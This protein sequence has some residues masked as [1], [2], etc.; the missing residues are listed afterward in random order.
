MICPACG[1]KNIP[2]DDECESCRADLSSL[3]GVIPKSKI[4]KV[5]IEDSI[6]QLQ[7]REPVVVRPEATVFEAVRMMNQGKFGCVLVARNGELEG[8]LTER[9]ILFKLLSRGKDLSKV[10]VREVMTP[11]PETLSTD[12][13]LAYAVNKM[14]IGGFRHVPVLKKGRPVGIISSR[15]VLRYLSKLFP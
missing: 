6:S 11:H 3:D 9:D 4:E 7:P 12:D 10:L 5:L 1:H 15:D 8:I 2:G 14:S 13:T